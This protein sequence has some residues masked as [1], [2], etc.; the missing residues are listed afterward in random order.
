MQLGKYFLF[1][2]VL[3]LIFSCSISKHLPEN[4]FLLDKNEI[5]LA[6]TNGLKEDE[7]R[8]VLRQTTNRETFGVKWRVRLFNAIDSTKVANKRTKKNTKNIQKNQKR[9]N[10]ADAINAKRIQQ[11]RENGEK[12]YKPKEPKLKDL[13]NPRKFFRE[14]L[15]YNVGEQAQVFDSSAMNRSVRQ[16]ELLLKNKGFFHGVVSANVYYK[17]RSRVDVNY[18]IHPKTAYKVDS[19]YVSSNNRYLS[20][21]YEDYLSDENTV[22][23]P[24]M[25][26]DTDVLAE[27][28]EELTNYFKN[29]G[30]YGFS[31]SYI[32]FEVDTLGRAQSAVIGVVISER[33]TEG[34]S[35]KT[36]APTR[37]NKVYFHI[38]DTL[39]YKGNFL[40]EQLKP[41]GLSS[42]G[43]TSL[44][45]LDTLIYDWYEGRNAQF[46][47]ATFFYN[48]ELFVSPELIEYQNLLEDSNVYKQVFL[49]Q[50]FNRLIQ[51][52]LFQQIRPDIV[53]NADHSI[54]VHYRLVPAKKQLFSFQ[55]RGTTSNG[56]LGLVSAVNYQHKN[57]FGGGEKLKLSFSGGVESQPEIEASENQEGIISG[58]GRSFNT[59]EFG[60]RVELEVPGLFPVKITKLSKRQLPKTL[61]ST[62]YN[63]Q[64]REEF[65]RELFQLDYQWKFY[66]VKRTQVFTLSVPGIGGF[67]FISISDD[68]IL[69]E[70][71]EELNDLFLK[72]AYSNQFIWKD[73][74]F[75]YQWSN[76]TVKKGSVTLSYLG[77]L[78]LAG[79]LANLVTRKATP[80]EDGVKELFGVRFSQFTRLDNDFR[81]NHSLKGERSL[82]YRLQAGVG[83]PYGNNAPN[84]PFDYSFFAGGANDN[85]GFRARTLGPGVY[86]YYLDTTRTATEIGD[87]RLG[88]SM[89]YRFRI[90][91][92]FKGAVF[93][94]MG[95]VWN[96]NEDPNRVGGA[97]TSDWYKQLA[98]SG[99]VGVRMD[100]DF[101]IIRM[102]LAMPFRNPALPASSRWVFQSQ[103]ALIDE[104]VAKYGEDWE[105]LSFPNPFE[106]R[107]Q[108][109]I[110][111]PF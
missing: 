111:Y 89:E 61:I 64:R 5:D 103:Q 9:R 6:K 68:A 93:S 102:D 23:K 100:L 10:K 96:Y 17:K 40:K 66:D 8:A 7:V 71:L 73:L 29:N 55:P 31:S 22:I 45:T 12:V 106:P 54:D 20:A 48:G 84:L 83:I 101:L 75:S 99:G 81:M 32:N 3:G 49:E 60:P 56:F 30:I 87:V 21:L 41:R 28:R 58:L 78:D 67:Q 26:Y 59:F 13:E 107:L 52:D 88:F 72:N 27:F 50:S 70:R 63:F 57:I 105:K 74:K 4:K 43:L 39:N 82:N 18:L 109:G 95:N 33:Q 86:K 85:R 90:S 37:V 97:F 34:G 44:P 91:G 104:K 80:N 79:H 62:A 11:A 76:A 24:Y 2:L 25:R 35:A 47:K 98:I 14:W 46:R 65:R 53:E 1:I 110:G 69:Q 42:I 94:D 16:I 38:V 19:F 108:I 36:F 51:L 77:N 15:K 92:M